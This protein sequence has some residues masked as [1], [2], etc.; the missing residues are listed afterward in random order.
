M[1]TNPIQPLGPRGIPPTPDRP[2]KADG[3]F[4]DILAREIARIEPPADPA[5]PLV[6]ESLR[7]LRESL[8]HLTAYELHAAD[9]ASRLDEMRHRLH[10]GESVD[11]APALEEFNGMD[12]ELRS[13]LKASS[14]LP[15]TNS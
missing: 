12:R 6:Q 15:S 11:L 9:F 3:T 2:A 13:L 14:A 4:G 8:R 10:A 1:E 7:A 5:A